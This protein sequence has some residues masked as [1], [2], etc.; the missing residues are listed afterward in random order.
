MFSYDVILG[1]TKVVSR[2]IEIRFNVVKGLENLD[3]LLD[4]DAT[5]Q[6]VVLAVVRPQKL[7]HNRRSK[8]TH[9]VDQLEQKCEFFE[10]EESSTRSYQ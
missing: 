1:R 10:G 7:V 6:D 4:P 5:V 3:G 8:R 9:P 2:R